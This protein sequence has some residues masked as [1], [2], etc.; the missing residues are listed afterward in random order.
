MKKLVSVFSIICALSFAVYAQ[1]SPGKFAL[2]L[3]FN[4]ASIFDAA[5]GSMFYFPQ[6]N[7]R[8]FIA[9]DVAIRLG[10]NAGFSSS[11]DYYDPDLDDN[12]VSSS[13]SISFAPGIEKRFGADKFF[14]FLGA[15][16]PITNYSTKIVQTI[17]DDETV[18][19][20][21]NGGYFGLGLSAVIGAEYYLLPNFYLG[22]LFTPGFDFYKNK[23]RVSDGTVTMKGGTDTSFG[24]SSS[25][26]VR[27]GFRF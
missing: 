14:V 21:T 7:G 16:L 27:I 11:K 23:D 10:I 6:I 18:Y 17:G 19:E 5:A 26:G 3:N 20:N 9:S 4:P 22:V 1:D 12:E 13:T 24:I 2:D 15:E 25:S 8:Y